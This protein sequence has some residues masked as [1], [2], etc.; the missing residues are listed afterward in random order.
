[1]WSVPVAELRDLIRVQCA[2]P[3]RFGMTP[4]GGFWAVI[5]ERVGA[6]G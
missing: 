4:C 5:A 2:R 1:M 6:N 3:G